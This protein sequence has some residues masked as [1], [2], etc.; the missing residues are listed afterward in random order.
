METARRRGSTINSAALAAKVRTYAR[1]TTENC[2][3]TALLEAESIY[4]SLTERMMIMWRHC[5]EKHGGMI[6]DFRMDIT[7]YY[8]SDTAAADHRGNQRDAPG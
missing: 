4:A 2:L 1:F 6:Q 5:K 8:W 3:R 7:G